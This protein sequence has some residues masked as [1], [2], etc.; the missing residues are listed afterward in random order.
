[1]NINIPVCC[2]VMLDEAIVVLYIKFLVITL[3]PAP[4]AD[5][6]MQVIIFAA[7]ECAQFKLK[8]VLSEQLYATA[9]PVIEIPNRADVEV[10][11]E[12]LAVVISLTTFL[13]TFNGKEA[14]APELRIPVVVE[15]EVVVKD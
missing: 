13:L 2:A 6:Y 9:A 3:L 14:T 4:V 15:T 11:T 12:A 8:T 5:V 7:V 1:M 10:D